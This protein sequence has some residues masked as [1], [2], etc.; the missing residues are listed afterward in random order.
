M[1]PPLGQGEPKEF[2]AKPEIIV[3]LLNSGWHQCEP[4]A[5]DEEVNEHVG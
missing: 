3:P 1:I 2:E 4:P 5:T